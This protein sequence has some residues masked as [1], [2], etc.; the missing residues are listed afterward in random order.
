MDYRDKFMMNAGILILAYAYAVSGY[1]YA[2]LLCG[3]FSVMLA[4]LTHSMRRMMRNMPL[5][6]AGTLVQSTLIFVSFPLS[7]R[8]VLVLLAFCNT[9]VSVLWM[10][11]SLKAIRPGMR[12]ILWAYPVFLMLASLLPQSA[13][14]WFSGEVRE[15]TSAIVLVSLIFLPLILAY[16]RKQERMISVGMKRRR[17][18]NFLDYDRMARKSVCEK[19]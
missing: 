14:C 10:E 4:I 13:M 16:I 15:R 1:P 8:Y 6:S 11:S 12:Y 17:D 3:V 7:E 19:Q 18:Y 2:G 5:I 9:A